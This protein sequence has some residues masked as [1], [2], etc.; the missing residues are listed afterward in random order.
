MQ[1]TPRCTV[2]GAPRSQCW[3]VHTAVLMRD[4]LGYRVGS[5]Q[6]LSRRSV[7]RGVA[8]TGLEVEESLAYSSGPK[9]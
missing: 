8:G 5:C 4:W 6:D 2:E 9:P 7:G 3:S 1:P